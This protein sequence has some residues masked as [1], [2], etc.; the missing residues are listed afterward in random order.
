MEVN[1]FPSVSFKKRVRSMLKVDFKRMLILPFYY[2]MLGISIII[3][4]LVLVMT[5]L[6]AGTETI[7]QVTGNPVV[8]EQL[9]TNVWQAIGTI[10][11]NSSEMIL[12]ITTMCN[13]DMMFFAVAVLVCVFIGD[14]FRSGYS[15]NLFTVRSSKTD[16]VVSKTI[17]CFVGGVTLI[18]GY[19]IGVLIGGAIA[20]LSFALE[21]IN[22]INIIMCILS[23]IL[24]LGVFVPIYLVMCVVGKQKTWLSMVLSLSLSML[25]FMMVSSISPLNSTLINVILC[26][27]G[28]VLFSVGLGTISNKILKTTSL[29]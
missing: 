9:F 17:V 22:I 20:N 10:P 23:K 14:E 11:G 2:I 29:V 16:Y 21:G 27:A 8:M 24:L 4:I 15:K 5:T 19:F 25:L 3:P 7:D 13:I 26:S 12:D 1:K 18:I 28:A 6:M